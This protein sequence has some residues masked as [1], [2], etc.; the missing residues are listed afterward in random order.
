M[1]RFWD[2]KLSGAPPLLSCVVRRPEGAWMRAELPPPVVQVTPAGFSWTAFFAFM[3]IALAASLAAV[4]SDLD[5]FRASGQV[6]P[7]APGWLL[8]AF[9]VALRMVFSGIGIGSGLLLAPK[10]GLGRSVVRSWSRDSPTTGGT[11]TAVVAIP[12]VAGFSVGLLAFGWLRFV[13][14]YLVPEL[15]PDQGEGTPAWKVL[16]SCVSAGVFEEFLFRFGVMTVLVW[17]GTLVTRAQPAKTGVIWV[18]MVLATIPFG[19][20]H[21][22][23]FEELSPSLVTVVMVTNAAGGLMFGWLYWRRGIEAAILAHV[24]ADVALHVLGPSLGVVI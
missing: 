10:V 20:V 15:N 23:H 11:F 19:L 9:A 14:L 24:S 6:P 18:G 16:L 17:I 4:P 8:G 5:E 21:L 13:G 2:F 7:E 3:T 22:N 12:L 1:I